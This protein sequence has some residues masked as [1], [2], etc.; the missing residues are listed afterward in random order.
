MVPGPSVYNSSPT[1][2]PLL[3]SSYVHSGDIQLKNING[4]KVEGQFEAWSNYY[5]LFVLMW[6]KPKMKLL[7]KRTRI[8]FQD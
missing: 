1:N 4:E 2:N 3:P 6:K 8:E 7:R 5:N